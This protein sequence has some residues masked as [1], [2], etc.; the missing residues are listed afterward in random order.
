M[1]SPDTSNPRADHG[2]KPKV[3]H[4]T[5]P[6][7]PLAGIRVVDL[8]RV[9]SGPFCAMLLGDMGAEVIKIERPGTG[10]D[11][12][13]FGPPFQG[14]EAAYF[15]SVN[16]NKKSVTLDLKSDEG[17]ALLWRLIE[18]ADVLIENF[19]PSAMDRLG[20]SYAAVAARRPSIVYASIS[21]FGA[22]GPEA[23]RPGYDLIVQGESGL[24]DITGPEDGAPHKFGTS[25]GDMVAGMLA[26]QGI[27]SALY[28]GR[29]T[30]QGQHV[31]VSM[32]EGLAS[33]LTYQAGI[34]YATGEAPRRAGNK[35]PTIVPYET[36][37]VADGWLNVGVANDGLWARFCQAIDRAD[38][39]DDPRFARA[40]DRVRNRAVL[41]PLLGEIL[42]AKSRDDW[43]VALDDVG[44]PCGAIRTI[45]EVCESPTLA[46]R[47][48]LREM[49]HATAGTVRTIGNPVHFSATPITDYAPPPRLGEHT[50][51]VLAE[52]IELSADEIAGLKARGVV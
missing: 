27:V 6:G 1:P 51:E 46:A 52:L 13:A 10:D 35:H 45:A 31:T 8:T 42:K 23:S 38:I 30:G 40:P 44:V 19:R 3:D 34:Y 37:E 50:E 15:L 39:R 18:T 21:G 41:V 29:D 4:G 11:T 32:L 7:G 12:R 26:T 2:T 33:L 5:N 20:F 48:M 14:G 17:K 16:R 28:A 25:I 36:F 47:G 24:M 49:A 9:L 22:T 43:I